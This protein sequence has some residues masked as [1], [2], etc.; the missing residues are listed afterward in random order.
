MLLGNGYLFVILTTILTFVLAGVCLLS[1]YLP[2]L[3][4]DL[5]MGTNNEL[6]P[7]GSSSGWR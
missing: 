7:L 1:K 2:H 4:N 6:N 3:Y 5:A